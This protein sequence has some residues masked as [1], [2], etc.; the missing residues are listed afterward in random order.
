MK[1]HDYFD[2]IT[3]HAGLVFRKIGLFTFFN[4]PIEL[5]EFT[6]IPPKVNTGILKSP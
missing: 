2:I 5:N 4:E 1:S 3:H 6:P